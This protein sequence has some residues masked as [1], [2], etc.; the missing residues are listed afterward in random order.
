MEPYVLY[1]SFGK[2]CITPYSNY[3][4]YVDANKVTKIEASSAKEAIETLTG[5]GYLSKDEILN[6]TG[7][8][9]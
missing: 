6:Y 5:Y 7:E 8:E 3:G 4:H 1:K 9:L 2:Y